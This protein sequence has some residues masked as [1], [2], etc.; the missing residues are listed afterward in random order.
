MQAHVHNVKGE[1]TEQIEI[2]D[3]VFKVPFNEAVVHQTLVMHLANRRLGTADTKR[4]GEVRGSGR[5]GTYF[6]K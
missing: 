6:G 2:R 1:I 3:D 5:S 4:R